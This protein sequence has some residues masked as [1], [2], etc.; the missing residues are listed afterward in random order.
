MSFLT[1]LPQHAAAVLDWESTYLSIDALAIGPYFQLNS[2]MSDVAVI[3]AMTVQDV[4]ASSRA[5]IDVVMA[6]V[7]EHAKIAAARGLELVAYEGGQHLVGQGAAERDPAVIALFAEANRDPGMGVLYTY[8][9]DQWKA[10][11][12]HLFIHFA[13]MQQGGPFGLLEWHDQTSS[14]KYDALQDFIVNNPR[15]W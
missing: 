12:G 7:L 2:S 8:Y 15:W 1:P 11:G 10:R 9:M 3:S 13:S 14:P 6:Q 4:L 5:N